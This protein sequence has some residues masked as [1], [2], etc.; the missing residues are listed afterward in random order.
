VSV[1]LLDEDFTLL[2]QICMIIFSF[3]KYLKHKDFRSVDN[4]LQFIVSEAYVYIIMVRHQY[5]WKRNPFDFGVARGYVLIGWVLIPG[6]GKRF[7]S[8]QQQ[9]DWL[10]DPHSLL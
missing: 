8:I 3:A 9:P 1:Q 7:F 10:G 4:R 6:R 2:I 5:A